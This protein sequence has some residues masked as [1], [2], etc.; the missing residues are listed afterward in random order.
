MYLKPI[1]N[2]RINYLIVFNLN[3]STILRNVILEL[4]RIISVIR[5]RFRH[6]F[7]ELN[8]VQTR[9]DRYFTD[10]SNVSLVKNQVK[11]KILIT[12]TNSYYKLSER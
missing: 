12:N 2:Y 3:I 5:R 11:I 7:E 10:F 1:H 4:I 9:N 6:S 8:H